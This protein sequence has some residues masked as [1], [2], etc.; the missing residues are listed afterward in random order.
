[1]NNVLYENGKYWITTGRLGFEVY[2]VGVTHSTRC[3]VIGFN[4]DIGLGLP[5]AISECDRRA[6]AD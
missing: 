3:A 1:M 5:K 4:A 6:N 2:K